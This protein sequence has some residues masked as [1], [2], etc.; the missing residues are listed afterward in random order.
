VCLSR[1]T[2]REF[3]CLS[4]KEQAYSDSGFKFH[5]RTG[6]AREGECALFEGDLVEFDGFRIERSGG[7]FGLSAA[8]STRTI[9]GRVAGRRGGTV[10]IT[11]PAD[12]EPEGKDIQLNGQVISYR[13]DGRTFVFEVPVRINDWYK[14]Y[15]ILPKGTP[16]LPAPQHPPLTLRVP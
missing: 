14:V 8:A 3:L 16:P 13:L 15:A 6:Y 2:E 1:G 12:F 11:P 10:R 5:G 7:D 4:D 9:I